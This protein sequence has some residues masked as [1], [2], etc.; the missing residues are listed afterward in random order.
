MHPLGTVQNELY[1]VLLIFPFESLKHQ[2]LRWKYF[3]TAKWLK[4]MCQCFSVM[5]I[6][7]ESLRLIRTMAQEPSPVWESSLHLSLKARL[8][9]KSYTAVSVDVSR[10]ARGKNRAVTS[11]YTFT[12]H[13]SF[14]SF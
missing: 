3:N 12:V 1:L 11:S 10:H 14:T 2:S 7:P 6:Q 9:F 5:E 4:K 13:V 8:N